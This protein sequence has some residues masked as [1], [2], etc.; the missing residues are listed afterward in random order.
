MT[1]LDTGLTHYSKI[2]T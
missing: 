1:N 2:T